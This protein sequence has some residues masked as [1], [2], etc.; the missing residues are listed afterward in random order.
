MGFAEAR[1]ITMEAVAC[2]SGP[3]NAAAL[4]ADEVDFVNN[5]PDNMLGIRNAGSDVVM[6]AQSIDYHFFDVVVSTNGAVPTMDCD[7]GDWECAMA[8]LNGTNVGVVARG[9]A[10]EQIARQ[11]LDSAGFDPEDTTY[12]ATGL[13]AGSIAAM[14]SG[15]VDWCV[16]FEP[17]LTTPVMIGVAY[18]PFTLRGGDGPDALAWP[19]LVRTTSRSTIEKYPNFVR[20]YSAAAREAA[21]WMRD[22]RDETIVKIA[23]Y[24]TGGDAELAAALYDNNIASLSKTGVLDRAGIENNIAYALGRGIIAETMSFDEVAVDLEG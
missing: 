19:S 8:A 2:S 22:N 7:Q 4:I 14:D 12:I 1:G 5:T 23:E 21:D 20:H 18:A 3:A 17:G 13:A 6:F 11:L 15:E 24:L 10:A 16:C 9:A